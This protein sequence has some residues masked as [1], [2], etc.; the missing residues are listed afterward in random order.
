[1]DLGAV[2]STSTEKTAL[3]TVFGLRSN[4]K[5]HRLCGNAFSQIYE[6]L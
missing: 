4:F 6:N 1:M 3:T 5:A 2:P